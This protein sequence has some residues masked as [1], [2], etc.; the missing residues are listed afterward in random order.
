[1]VSGP[2]IGIFVAVILVGTVADPTLSGI[3]KSQFVGQATVPA[4]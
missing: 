3:I 2:L 1:M 4:E